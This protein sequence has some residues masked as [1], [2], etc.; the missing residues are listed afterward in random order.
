MSMENLRAFYDKVE[1]DKALQAKL[2]ALGS[3]KMDA[4]I[5]PAIAE[6]V[7]IASSMGFEIT[8]EELIEARKP[9]SS[10]VIKFFDNDPGD[11]QD[12]CAVGTVTVIC[13]QGIE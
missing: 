3:V 1:G 13:E 10:E 2:N 8:A 9:A 4:P 6:S 11:W 7:K 5:G 12:N